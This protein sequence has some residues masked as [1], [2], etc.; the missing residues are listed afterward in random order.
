MHTEFPQDKGLINLVR[1]VAVAAG[2]RTHNLQFF[3]WISYQLCSMN[4]SSH[5]VLPCLL[6]S[7]SPLSWSRSP[8]SPFVL[9]DSHGSLALLAVTSPSR[10]PDQRVDSVWT[11]SR[12]LST[13]YGLP[14]AS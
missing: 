7:Q 2:S 11:R 3:V 13:T 10:L 12:P 9:A 5:S 14:Q 6:T 8:G 4:K 1:L